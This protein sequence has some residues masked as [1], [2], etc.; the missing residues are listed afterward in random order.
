M[1]QSKMITCCVSVRD[2]APLHAK[3]E[4]F[5]NNTIGRFIKAWGCIWWF[6]LKWALQYPIMYEKWV[7][8]GKL[9]R[10]LCAL[11]LAIGYW[12]HFLH[13]PF[14]WIVC[15][16]ISF[17]QHLAKRDLTIGAK[18]QPLGKHYRVYHNEKP[19]TSNTANTYIWCS[20]ACLSC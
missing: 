20:Q 18:R 2:N 15:Q 9:P 4:R 19:L 13:L 16:G 11:K 8:S 3:G 14:S 5:E 10:K 1:I 17:C 6:M 7:E 12:Q